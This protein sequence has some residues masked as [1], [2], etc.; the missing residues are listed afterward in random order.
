VLPAAQHSTTVFILNVGNNAKKMKQ[1]NL[2]D[3]LDFNSSKINEDY[4]VIPP[5]YYYSLDDAF[6]H[7]FQTFRDKKDV[8]DY[9]V[10]HEFW[11]VKNFNFSRI[12][13]DHATFTFLGFHR[14][15]E[16]LLKDLLRKVNPNLALKFDKTDNLFELVTNNLIVNGQTIEFREALDRINIIFQQYKIDNLSYKFSIIQNFN[17]IVSGDNYDTLKNLNDWRNRI[18]H[19]GLTIPNIIGLDY[20][21]TQRILPLVKKIIDIELPDIFRPFYLKTPSGI[22]I[23]EELLKIK[24]TYLDFSRKKNVDILYKHL[25]KIGHLKE[26]GRSS[27]NIYPSLRTGQPFF[28]PYDSEFLS[29]VHKIAENEK[30]NKDFYKLEKCVCCSQETAVVYKKES[31][32]LINKEKTYFYWLRC[33]FCDYCIRDNVGEPSIFG[34]TRI[35]YFE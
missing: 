23:L 10:H 5:I 12:S 34:L 33:Y 11:D 19:N 3:F 18:M 1:Q 21:I 31:L 2:K 17:F 28:E 24:F 26:L 4:E 27:F 22:D 13:Y 8:Y 9:S 30:N 25:I 14:F 15:F 29:R 32:S 20:F 7:Y 6:F 16:L 35:R